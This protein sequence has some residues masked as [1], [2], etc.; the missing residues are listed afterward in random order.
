MPGGSNKTFSMTSAPRYWFDWLM[1]VVSDIVSCLRPMAI[2]AAAPRLLSRIDFELQTPVH[3]WQDDRPMI[4]KCIT[5]AKKLLA[6][7]LLA[8]IQLGCGEGDGILSDSIENIDTTTSSGTGTSASASLDCLN[9]DPDKVYLRG[10]L[11]EGSGGRDAI[12]D[13]ADPTRFCLG[14]ASG[15]SAPGQVTGDGKY[16]HEDSETIYSMIPEPFDT[17]AVGNE[18]YPANPL[19]NDTVLLTSPAPLC[20]IRSIMVNSANNII[21]YS[22]PNNTIHT[23][24]SVPYYSLGNG[25]LL[26]VLADGSM[27]VAEFN[28]LKI[29]DTSLVETPITTPAT[30]TS[31]F[32]TARLFT[33]PV[34]S[35]PSVWVVVEDGSNP[36]QR[37][38]IDLTTLILRDDGDFAAAPANI[39]GND[40]FSKLKLDG[41]G[42]LWQI[43]DD[44]SQT[45]VDV[46]V[47]R[48]IISSGEPASVVY[49]EADDDGSAEYFVKIH[50]SY[51]FTGL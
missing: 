10:T 5:P 37:W 4:K 6:V 2:S 1:P 7:T 44:T 17:D 24:A 15:S 49:S 16:I 50:I 19:A 18:S 9:L 28:T 27:L 35:N 33:D 32:L 23:E 26:S 11:V 3:I 39:A 12:I 42:N 34:T 20:G 48:P 41:D 13:P 22:C 38:S 40:T 14:F 45:F 47:K 30:V 31:S 25:E 21:Y 36:L 51:L 43:G 8:G 29:V 46:I